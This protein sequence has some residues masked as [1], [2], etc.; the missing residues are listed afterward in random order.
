MLVNS[1]R[2]DAFARMLQPASLARDCSINIRYSV[3]GMPSQGARRSA[4]T[5]LLAYAPSA[6]SGCI[7]GRNH[8]SR[9]EPGSRKHEQSFR[10]IRRYGGWARCVLNGLK[11]WRTPGW[12]GNAGGPRTWEPRYAHAHISRCETSAFPPFPT[13]PAQLRRNRVLVCLPRPFGS[14]HTSASDWILEAT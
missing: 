7:R 13:S 2:A 6:R 10:L 14:W 8:Q 9:K 12:W 3:R 1:R 5:R 11:S 4:F